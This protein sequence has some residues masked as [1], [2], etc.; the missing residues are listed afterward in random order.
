MAAPFRLFLV[1]EKREIVGNADWTFNFES[2]SGLR[3]ITN[4]AVDPCPAAKGDCSTFEG[5]V[6]GGLPLFVHG[7]QD[8]LAKLP[9]SKL[10]VEAHE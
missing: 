8:K 2:G 3:E 1:H 7:R 9:T 10:L 5:T 6:T 4:D